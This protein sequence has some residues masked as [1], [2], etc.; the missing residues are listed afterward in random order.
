VR[1]RQLGYLGAVAALSLSVRM[2]AANCQLQQLGS[3]AVD[4]H[5]LA[6]IVSARINGTEARFL[7][8]TG[9]YYSILSEE[10]AEKYHLQVHSMPG[11]FFLRGTGGDQRARQTYVKSLE[12]I[13]VPVHNIQFLVIDT[14]FGD[15]YAGIFGQNMLRFSDVEYDL[16]NGVVR[17]FKPDGC[18][19]QPLA[20]WATG[21]PYTAIDLQYIDA[22]EDHLRGTAMINGKRMTVFLDTGAARSFLSLQAAERAGITPDSPGVK[23]LGSL[24]GGIGPAHDKVWSAPVDSFQLGGEK[25]EHTHL[26]IADFDPAHRIGETWDDMPDM[27]LGEDFFLSHRIYVAYS[28]RKLYFTY[29]GGPL[30]NLNLPEFA[31]AAPKPQASPG[32]TA[33][34]GAGTHGQSDADA[35]TDADGFRRRGMGYAARREF[36]LALADLTHACELAPKDV[37][38]HYD[39]GIVYG[40]DHQ[41]KPALQDFTTAITL[42]PD[43][44]DALLARAS[45]LQ[46]H[47]DTDP[48]A[49]PEIKSDL[50]TVA[51][52]AAPNADVRLHLGDMY[53]KIGDYPAAIQQI[54]Q[55]LS[56]HSYPN[57]RVTGLNERCWWQAA[58][59]RDLRAALKDCN[60]ALDL[61]YDDAD[62]RDSRGL[63]YLRMGDLNDAIE[64][65]DFAL[66]ANPRET[67][68]LYGRGLAELRLG[69]TTQGKT[70]L[71]A[72]EKLDSGVAGRFARM[73][74]DTDGLDSK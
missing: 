50:D 2:A 71:T 15:D 57:D 45:L 72:A 47:P 28:Q 6:P 66:R 60:H 32:A 44:I 64:D 16:A 35:P 48:T 55:W 53:G 18:E 41:F 33:A 21:T 12:F 49:A 4:M 14:R 17:L 26:L 46:S 70:D 59:N 74:L 29:N 5:G 31:G 24:A 7:L 3:L 1:M 51:R 40:R 19:R 68:S 13:G 25:V 20:Y 62:V 65:Y 67:T 27:L 8:D 11:S 52:L 38:A 63:V 56:T 73:G 22:S 30:F 36:D 9:A 42:Q 61:A 58:A 10:A 43:D 23:F 34:A 69:E 54:D 39:R 37:D